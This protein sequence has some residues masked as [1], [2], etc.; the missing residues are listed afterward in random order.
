MIV[1]GSSKS[2]LIVKLT[3]EGAQAAQ[4][5]PA[6]FLLQQS[7][8]KYPFTSATF[9]E[10]FDLKCV[11][12]RCRCRRRRRR[13]C[14]SSVPIKFPCKYISNDYYVLVFYIIY[15]VSFYVITYIQYKYFLMITMHFIVH[16][17]YAFNSTSYHMYIR[18][19]IYLIK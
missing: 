2:Q 15:H 7:I 4:T 11:V 18:L 17:Y 5:I 16:D 8:P 12:R 19:T 9:A 10:Y 1:D 14:L 3:S 13:R 6:S